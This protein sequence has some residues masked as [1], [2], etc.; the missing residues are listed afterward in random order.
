MTKHLI[1]DFETMGTNVNDCAVIDCSYFVF[2]TDKM[3]SDKPYTTR[4]IA[5][6]QKAKLSIKEQVDKYE[7]K[8]Y[9]DTIK[10]WESQPPEIQKKIYPTKTDKSIAE[11]TEDFLSYLT[12]S[13]KIDYWWSRSNSFD[14]PILWRLFDSQNKGN[15]LKEHIPH[16]KLRD[17]RTYIDAKLNFPKVNGFM[18]I[19]DEDFWNKVFQ[20]HDS[21]WDI[22][23]DILRIQAIIRA[24]NDLETITR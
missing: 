11:F 24:E 6:I 3:V 4:S 19:Q 12:D 15:H 8:V 16:W 10:F 17:T 20:L 5:E 7:W 1:L 22:L 13:G 18:P 9:S 21:S 23:A 14:P 2:N